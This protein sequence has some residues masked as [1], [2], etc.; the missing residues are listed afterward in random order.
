MKY[1]FPKLINRSEMARRIYPFS[2]QPAILINNKINEL[3]RNS[4]N[5]KDIDACI[6]EV[7]KTL[8]ELQDIKD[9]LK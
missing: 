6:K 8:Q 5:V 7:I 4:L 3:S 9:N 1:K 2:K